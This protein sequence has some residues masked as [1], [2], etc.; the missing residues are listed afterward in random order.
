M[1]YQLLI[2]DWDGTL[3][4][5]TGRIIS[6]FKGGARELGLRIPPDEDVR[7]IIGLGLKEAIEQVMP[8]LNSTQ[9][10]ALAQAYSRH[11]LEVDETPTA[12]FHAVAEGLEHL[13]ARGFRLAV[14]T[15]KS[16]RGLDRVMQETGLGHLFE[17]TRCADETRSKPHPRM[18][19]EILAHTKVSVDSAL[20]IGDTD[21]DLNMATNAGM[22]ALA[23]TYGAHE[24]SRLEQAQPTHR[25]DSFVD[26]ID[27]IQDRQRIEV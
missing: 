9:V 25:V 8:E 3:I 19:E 6:S 10:D 16:R 20:M 22:D 26:F 5:S 2:F 11:Y 14:A 17:V 15:G 1:S 13:R 27:W 7:N 18:L 24:L 4:D 23:V 12:L 21:Y